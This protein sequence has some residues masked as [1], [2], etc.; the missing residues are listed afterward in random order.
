MDPGYLTKKMNTWKNTKKKHKKH[1]NDC[2][3]NQHYFAEN[4]VSKCTCNRYLYIE[5]KIN[6][7]IL[8]VNKINII[9]VKIVFQNARVTDTCKQNKM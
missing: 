8:T 4:S 5:Q 9:S 2:Q 7:I 1:Y 3:Q 6:I